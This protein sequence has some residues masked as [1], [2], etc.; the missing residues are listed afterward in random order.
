MKLAIVHDFLLTY[1][2]AERVLEHVHEMY[3]EAP[4][5]TLRYSPER[6][7]HRMDGWDIRTSM[8]ERLPVLKKRGHTL[9]MPLYPMAVE[10]WDFSGFD[11]VLSLSS[12]F[13]H[14]VITQPETTHICYYHTP[15]RFLWDY[16][17]QYMKE[18]AWDR[19]FKGA[20]AQRF[21]HRLR[22]WDYLAA[23]RPDMMLGNSQT[24][25]DRIHKFYRRDA[26]VLYPG[27]DSD[28]YVPSS[29]LHSPSSDYY[30]TVCRLTP[31]KRIE[32]AVQ[33]CTKLGRELHVIGAG[34][35]LEH[36]QAMA[37]PTIQFT[38]F[39]ED[40]AVRAETQG[41]KALLWP[42]IDD[43]GLVPVEAMAC[44]VP[45]IAYNKG[46]TTE[47]VVDG[48]TGVLFDDHSTEGMIAAIERFEKIESK[49]DP[50]AIHEHAQQFSKEQFQQK[51]KRVIEGQD[52]RRKT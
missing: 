14:G 47:T 46:G 27:F 7:H 3:P 9:A 29:V 34:E 12:A 28:F 13:A 32:L 43:F 10:D 16:H 2:G 4:I 33:A 11:V 8:I 30:I 38:G 19:G 52:L 25:A 42:C 18:K 31:P 48:T 24:V 40:G 1:G 23:Q 50:K 5:F 51:L 35:E 17:Y 20:V 22:E 49:L 44:G 15:A 26:T 21:L 36:L 6:M 37:G 45:V 41:A 39:L